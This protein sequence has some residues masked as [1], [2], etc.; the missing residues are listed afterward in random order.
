MTIG[1]LAAASHL[2]KGF[3]S[4]LERGLSNAS[5]ESLA[6]IAAA[7]GLALPTLLGGAFSTPRLNPAE[8]MPQVIARATFRK[9]A[10]HLTVIASAGQGT[11]AL[12]VLEKGDLLVG[13]G[14]GE[15]TMG[16]ASCY[17]TKGEIA[18]RQ[19]DAQLR[20]GEGDAAVWS[21]TTAFELQCTSAI[22]ASLVVTTPA[23]YE[24]QV[25][26]SK[27]EVQ[28]QTSSRVAA[29][30]P[31]GGPFSLVAMRAQRGAGQGR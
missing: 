13:R 25:I 28:A 15:V 17:I 24:L 16:N 6:R 12:V 4:Q 21:V 22:E 8:E 2:S 29:V 23:G 10:P 20:A 26:R 3:I 9:R 19:G 31:P 5:L 7:L 27:T 1:A 30:V 11:L 14:A 18:L